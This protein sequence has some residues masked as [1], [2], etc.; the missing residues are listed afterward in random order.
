VRSAPLVKLP[1][2][3]PD[4]WKLGVAADAVSTAYQAVR[5]SG[6][7]A[8]DVAA[9]VGVGGVGGFTAQIAAALGAHVLAL[10]VKRERLDLALRHGAESA[11]NV[12]DLP[13]KA[14]KAEVRALLKKCAAPSFRLRIFE[15]TGT[16]AGQT[17]AFGLLDRGAT[18]VQVGYTPESVD[19][20][21]SNL[22]A[23]DATIHGTWGCPI[24]AYPAVVD[25]IVRGAV[26]LDPFVERAP[27]SNVNQSLEA[28]HARRLERRLVLD[29]RS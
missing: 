13:A 1:K 11:L 16:R 5:R 25:L 20:R 21:L 12:Q 15:C 2:D 9:I 14:V 3:L 28:M 29:P 22:M 24:E 17:L 23:F 6:L 10:D 7:A 8:G 4:V 18:L 27:M 26:K 19:V